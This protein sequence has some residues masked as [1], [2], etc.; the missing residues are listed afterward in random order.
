MKHFYVSLCLWLLAPMLLRAQTSKDFSVLVSADVQSSAP[1]I[2]LNWPVDNIS[3]GYQVF[4]KTKSATSWGAAIASLPGSATTYTDNAA[5]EGQAYEYRIIKSF[6]ANNIAYNGY[7]YIFAGAKVP[8]IENRDKIILLVD[9]EFTSSLATEIKRLEMDLIGEGWQVIRYDVDRTDKVTDVKKIITTAYNANPG[10]V[11]ALFLLGHIPV[12]YSGNYAVDHHFPDHVGA[13]PADVYYGS[14]DDNA[15]TDYEVDNDAAARP[16]NHNVPD[17]GKFDNDVLPSDVML[18]IGRVDFH[19]LPAFKTTETELMRRYLN[20]DHNWRTKVYSATEKAV[21][22]DNFGGASGEAF[23]ASGYY[24][25]APMFG[26]S[27]VI[28]ADYINSLTKD[29]FMWSYGCGGGSYTSVGGVATT[30]DFVNRKINTVFTMLFGS[31]S[32]DWDSQDNILRASLAG[33]NMVLASAW[34][35][36]P[37]WNFHHMALGE[38]IGYSTHLTQNDYINYFRT[39]EF[40]HPPLKKP[41]DRLVTPALLGDPTIRMHVVAPPAI[42]SAK[43]SNATVTLSW[44]KSADAEEY[45]IYR[46]TDLKSPF[47]RA[48]KVAATDTVFTDNAPL[49]IGVKNYY[50]VRAVKLQ[51]SASG[52]YYN[53]S[54]GSIDSVNVAASV[55]ENMHANV[56]LQV[57]PNPSQNGRFTIAL[58][59]GLNTTCTIQ[60]TDITG[61]VVYTRQVNTQSLHANRL[62]FSLQ[63]MAKGMY[64]LQVNAGNGIYTHKLIYR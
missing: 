40:Y 27:N 33:D 56:A 52:T 53:L 44:N 59:P 11:K 10:K 37:H 54:Q 12:P 51:S 19:N 47:V 32:G 26:E 61:R 60:V 35:G 45:Y 55:S 39:K 4:R 9:K 18:Q 34:S 46:T 57:Y 48:A 41:G 16:Q 1:K 58:V 13:W 5:V 50:M 25:F 7:G 30:N 3:S 6:T 23:A 15:W 24:N 31:Y 8:A 64:T 17:D 22:E 43:S 20:K 28:T 62:D 36:R 29:T 2:I 21:I 38:N 14:M 42:K 63:Q 49:N